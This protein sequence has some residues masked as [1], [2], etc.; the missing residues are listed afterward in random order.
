[1]LYEINIEI[2]Q[3]SP[4]LSIQAKLWIKNLN[5]ILELNGNR[6]HILISQC[7]HH[8]VCMQQIFFQLLVHTDENGTQHGEILG[9]RL[10]SYIYRIF[11]FLSLYSSFNQPF[12]WMY[13][14]IFI[15]LKCLHFFHAIIKFWPPKD[16]LIIF[17]N[18]I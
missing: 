5:I 7:F 2:V 11:F 3:M 18:S 9:L 1:M 17:I 4:Y 14:Y 8:L 10:A 15:L 12:V 13:L 6:V 16:Y